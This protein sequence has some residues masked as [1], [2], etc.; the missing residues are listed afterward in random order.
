M[1]ILFLILGLVLTI[2]PQLIVQNMYKSYQKLETQGGLSGAEVARQILEKNGITDVAIESIEGELSDHYDPSKKVVRLSENNYHGTNVSA[3]GV[4]AHEVGHALQDATGYLPMK[5]RAGIFPV[6]SLGSTIGPWLMIGG[7][8]LRGFVNSDLFFLVALVGFLLYVSVALFQI[9][10][11]PVELNASKRAVGALVEG[12][13]ITGKTE[14]DGSQKV[15]MAA[16]LTYVAAALY[17]IM[18]VI[19]WAWRLFGSSNR[20]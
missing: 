13:Y 19:Y 10:T 12:G 2:I 1:I 15:L 8:I 20:N 7:L 3:I 6:V 9:I 11:L 5:A 18:E 14:L 16:A 17:S 4:A